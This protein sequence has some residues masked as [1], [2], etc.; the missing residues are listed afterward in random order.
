MEQNEY[1]ENMAIEDDKMS[2]DE[3]EESFW[4]Y[5]PESLLSNKDIDNNK[6]WSDMIVQ[7]AWRMYVYGNV[8]R[9]FIFKIMENMIYSYKRYMPVFK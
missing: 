2:I 8:D 1:L 6:D 9:A 3:F 4:A 7:E 5:I